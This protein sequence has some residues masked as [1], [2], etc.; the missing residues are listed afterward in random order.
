MTTFNELR[1]P[2][3]R[4]LRLCAVLCAIAPAWLLADALTDHG[5]STVGRSGLESL[6]KKVSGRDDLA[7]SFSGDSI[8]RFDTVSDGTYF[9]TD[10]AA[11][12]HPFAMY[13]G[14][15]DSGDLEVRA[16]SAGK[17]D[18]AERLKAR[19]V[20]AISEADDC[21]IEAK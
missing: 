18:E 10:P 3:A 5:I 20:S 12:A 9:F 17:V 19:L 6:R 11:P 8:S 16:W 14:R 4:L 7:E 1:V 15:S 2:M 21:S 13:C